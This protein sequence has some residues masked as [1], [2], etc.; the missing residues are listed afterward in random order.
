MKGALL[1]IVAA[2]TLYVAG[3]YRVPE[4]MFAA[5]AEILLLALMLFASRLLRRRISAVLAPASEGTQR[6]EA[7]SCELR[8]DNRG[9]LP[10]WFWDARVCW[11]QDGKKSKRKLSGHVKGE[12]QERSEFAISAEHCG[13]VTLTLQKLIVWDYMKLSGRRVKRKGRENVCRIP[14]FP[15]RHV[16]QVESASEESVRKL[17]SSQ[18][19]LPLVG[20]DIREVQ[21]YREYQE[22]DSVKNIHWKLSARSEELW[23]KEFSRSDERRV[24][25]FLDL[26]EENAQ[27]A[28]ERDAFYE[29]LFALL[30]G[31]LE[32][33][34]RVHLF[35]YDW[36]GK[37][38]AASQI[39]GEAACLETF[40]EL[41]GASLIPGDQ[42][43]QKAYWDEKNAQLGSM[44]QLDLKLRLAYGGAAPVLL[45]QFSFQHY[46][47]EMEGQ[48]VVIP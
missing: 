34:D 29:V 9:K 14:V 39:T 3:I 46:R 11:E 33:Y 6:G 13:F 23:V 38:M 27:S 25:L 30:L 24:A 10:V 35:W 4:G 16:L 48:K 7:L 45:K 22:G 37:A 1:L 5:M 43:D 26:I 32:Q 44:L 8:V 47:E 18:T 19:P 17:G 12:G 20:T 41:Y 28:D 36:R 40:A 42:V 21:Q 31:L 2:V 15:P